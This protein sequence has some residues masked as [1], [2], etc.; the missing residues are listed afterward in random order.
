MFC[1]TLSRHNGWWSLSVLFWGVEGPARPPREPE[2][3]GGLQQLAD[4]QG[5]GQQGQL[6]PLHC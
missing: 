1:P 6:L 2:D 3:P 4:Q 5:Q